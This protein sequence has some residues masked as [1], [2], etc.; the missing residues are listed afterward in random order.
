MPRFGQ[1][2]GGHQPGESAAHHRESRCCCHAA[3]PW[4]PREPVAGSRAGAAARLHGHGKPDLSVQCYGKLTGGFSK[5]QRL[6]D[7]EE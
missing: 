6:P 7:H 1:L 4:C 5:P 3:S 2:D